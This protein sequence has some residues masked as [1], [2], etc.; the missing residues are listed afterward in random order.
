M[1]LI[2]EP[3]EPIFVALGALH[4]GGPR[5]VLALLKRHG[6]AVQPG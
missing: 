6:F 5:G 2:V 3:N 4:L 1:L